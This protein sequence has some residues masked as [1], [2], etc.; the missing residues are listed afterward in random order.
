MLQDF[1]PIINKWLEEDRKTPR[2]QC[3]TVMRIYH[4][5]RDE[6]EFT[7]CDSTVKKYVRKKKYIMQT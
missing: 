5:L 4:R 3:H 1:I 6:R 2:K 7:G